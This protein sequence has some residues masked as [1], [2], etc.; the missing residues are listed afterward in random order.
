MP[1]VL[2]NKAYK[3]SKNLSRYSNSPYYYNIVDNN[4]TQQVF[5][6][7]WLNRLKIYDE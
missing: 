7:G 1:D 3:N 4:P 2:T 6:K 5:L